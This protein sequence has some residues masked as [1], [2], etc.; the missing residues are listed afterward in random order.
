MDH[1]KYENSDSSSDD[2]LQGMTPI[3]PNVLISPVQLLTKEKL[4]QQRFLKRSTKRFA[5]LEYHSSELLLNQKQDNDTKK[6]SLPLPFQNKPL[7]TSTFNNE[8]NSSLLS[9]SISYNKSRHSSSSSS[10]SYNRSHSS[11]SS[12]LISYNRSRSLSPSL[13]ISYNRSRSSSPSSSISYNRS[14]SSSSSSST[15]SLQNHRVFMSKK[16]RFEEIEVLHSGFLSFAQKQSEHA[17]K[18]LQCKF[19]MLTPTQAKESAMRELTTLPT[20]GLSNAV[21]EIRAKSLNRR[22]VMRITN[23]PR[24]I[25]VKP[26]SSKQKNKPI[27]DFDTFKKKLYPHAQGTVLVPFSP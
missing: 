4:A 19:P 6:I 21:L 2:N 7:D 20:I 27:H 16:R 26:S 17:R 15:Q 11:S 12:S 22:R 25:G 5:K 13:S 8:S 23:I 24:I 3:P 10:S 14:R 18:K 1:T 9:S